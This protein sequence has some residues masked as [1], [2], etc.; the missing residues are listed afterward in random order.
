VLAD[1]PALDGV[2]HAAVIPGVMGEKLLERADR[3]A[4]G[5]GN[6]LDTFMLQVRKQSATIDAQMPE[7]GLTREEPAEIAEVIGQGR[8]QANDLIFGHRPPCQMELLPL[9]EGPR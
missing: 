6:R 8:T 1:D 9:K 3:R 4:G 2:T 7:R 5:Q